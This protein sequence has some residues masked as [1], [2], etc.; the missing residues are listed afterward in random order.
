MAAGLAADGWDLVLS[1]WRPYDDRLGLEAGEDDPRDLAAQ[2]AETGVRVELVPVDLQ[3]PAAAQSLMASASQ[4]LGPVNAL[5]MSHCE[6]VKPAL[7][8]HS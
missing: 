7:Q 8:H 5:V 2:L 6:S 4:L 1:Y 3:D